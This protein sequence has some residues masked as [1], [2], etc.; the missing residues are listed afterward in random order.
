MTIYKTQI[1]SF[2]E[3]IVVVP[4]GAGFLEHITWRSHNLL[5]SCQGN[6]T[7]RNHCPNHELREQ[8]QNPGITGRPNS[9]SYMVKSVKNNTKTLNF[10]GVAMAIDFL[11]TYV[12]GKTQI[13]F[14]RNVLLSVF[15]V[16]SG[17]NSIYLWQGLP[18]QEI[19]VVWG[20][21]RFLGKG[22][23]WE[24]LADDK[25]EKEIIEI[26]FFGSLQSQC[27][28]WPRGESICK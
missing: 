28:I 2:I 22:R 10:C 6:K 24:G 3:N 18:L 9:K 25:S 8:G 1:L 16:G 26:V 12:I 4:Q 13:I 7:K 14:L 27:L 21:Q 19:D 15:L 17:V 23:D 5:I 11:L 20:V